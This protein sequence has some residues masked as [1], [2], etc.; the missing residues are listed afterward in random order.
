MKVE[1]KKETVN[2]ELILIGYRIKT[3]LDKLMFITL[4]TV[5]DV[6]NFESNLSLVST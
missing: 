6:N 4:M 3:I 5:N 2:I 1:I